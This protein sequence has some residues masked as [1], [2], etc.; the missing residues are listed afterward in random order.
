MTT[1]QPKR[2]F[3]FQPANDEEGK[4]FDLEINGEMVQCVA[5][6][7]GLELLEFTS[8][9]YDEDLPAGQRTTAVVRWLKRCMVDYDA[10]KKVVARH[11]ISIEG[12]M[13]VGGYLADYYAELPTTPAQSSPTGRDET[14]EPSADSSS[15]G[16]TSGKG[17]PPAT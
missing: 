10:F 5:D 1:S 3:S 2:A 14:G 6:V 15:S 17:S 4:P 16:V 9:V 13:E 11:K 12:L 8:A 7:D